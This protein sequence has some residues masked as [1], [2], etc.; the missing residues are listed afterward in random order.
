[1]KKLAF[2]FY[3]LFAFVFF[4]FSCSPFTHNIEINGIG[5]HP[6]SLIEPLPI[7]VGIYYENDFATFKTTQKVEIVRKGEVFLTFIDNIKMGKANIAL[8]D[9]IL[10]RVFREVTFVQHF[11][12]DSKDM[13][14][15]DLIIKPKIHKYSYKVSLDESSICIIYEISFYSSSGETIRPWLIEGNGSKPT[16]IEFKSEKTHVTE[17]TQMAMRQVAAK[18]MTDFCKQA[19]INKLFY[20][21]CSQ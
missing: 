1:M 7:K 14:H 19:D 12:E 8:F 5:T 4:I 17:L 18:F 2:I 3:S 11:S 13:Q 9:Y 16:E 20:K 21:E 10:P 6:P 15:N